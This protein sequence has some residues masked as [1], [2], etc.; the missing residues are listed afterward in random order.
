MGFRMST[1]TRYSLN[2]NLICEWSVKIVVLSNTKDSKFNKNCSIF[3][4]EKNW[5]I[6]KKLVGIVKSFFFLHHEKKLYL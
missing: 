5:N 4:L 2:I 6:E 3:K 1:Y